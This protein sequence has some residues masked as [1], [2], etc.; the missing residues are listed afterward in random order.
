MQ[1]RID[2][3]DRLKQ[4]EVKD[5]H[6]EEAM[7][8]SPSDPVEAPVIFNSH[9][10]MPPVNFNSIDSVAGVDESRSVSSM[11]T[12]GSTGDLGSEASTSNQTFQVASHQPVGMTHAEALK[13]AG[14]RGAAQQAQQATS[15]QPDTQQPASAA[16]AAVDISAKADSQKAAAPA[17]GKQRRKSKREKARGLLS[18][19]THGR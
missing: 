18:S 15:H 11:H 16:A 9:D 1:R 7:H 6:R 3:R 12:S 10:S 13:L 4:E 19:F 8:M 14:L 5:E 2:A 17:E